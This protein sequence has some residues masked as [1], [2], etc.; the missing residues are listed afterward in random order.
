MD[1][2]YRIQSK[3]IKKKMR[4]L[5]FNQ[6]STKYISD[7]VIIEK[8]AL[9]KWHGLSYGYYLKHLFF[10]YHKEFKEIFN[11][12]NP[13]GYKEIKKEFNKPVIRVSD[14]LFLEKKYWKKYGGIV[15]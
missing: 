2:D 6:K 11:E 7:L 10:K 14:E 8:I 13:K 5:V 15:E 12:L 3:Y 1:T 4:K 9:E